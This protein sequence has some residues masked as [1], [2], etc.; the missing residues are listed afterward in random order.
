MDKKSL[1]EDEFYLFE[2]EDGSTFIA[3]VIVNAEDGLFLQ[4]ISAQ[5]KAKEQLHGTKVFDDWPVIEN[6]I[7]KL[8]DS[9]SYKNI[10]KI[11]TWKNENPNITW[12]FIGSNPLSVSY[13]FKS[14]TPLYE[15]RS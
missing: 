2:Y 3:K 14:I 9:Y 13:R 11:L 4:I 10:N 7:P 8:P 5:D 12:N 1:V 6:E 15:Q